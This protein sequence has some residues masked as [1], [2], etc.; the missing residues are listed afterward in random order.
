MEQGENKPLKILEWGISSR[1]MEGQT[2]SG[3]LHFVHQMRD[4]ALIAVLDGL[5]H[6]VEAAAAAK[7]AISTLESCA[8]QSVIAI[9]QSCH[10]ALRGTRGVVMSLASFNLRDSTMTWIGVGNVE[11]RLLRADIESSPTH[12]SLVQRGGV[13]GYQ[14]PSLRG[15]VIPVAPGDTL[16][17]FTDGIE[18]G[19]TV[20]LPL[21]GPPQRVAEHIMAQ[22]RR[23]TDDALVLVARYIGAGS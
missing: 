5:G 12:E 8:H 14:L 21:V 18:S 11:G 17:F 3:D 10:E 6:G 22:H 23:G 16:L 9:I 20:V 2:E 19:F 1:A 15:T 4:G 13:I 7:K